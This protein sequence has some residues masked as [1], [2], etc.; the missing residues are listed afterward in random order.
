VR[1][2]SYVQSSPPILSIHL[3]QSKTDVF[4]KT[5]NV[6]ITQPTAIAAYQSYVRLRSKSSVQT[7]SPLFA[8]SNGEPL[9]RRTLLT[10]AAKLLA[11]AGIDTSHNRGISFRAGGATSL[12]EA[13]IHDRMIKIIGRWSGGSYARYIDTPLQQF[14]DATAK[15]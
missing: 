2:A 5:V 4:R 14:I 10:A 15:L 6:H 11:A 12:A 7:N 8:L 3:A 9:D 13:G 1:R